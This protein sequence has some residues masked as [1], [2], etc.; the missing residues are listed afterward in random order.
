MRG[1][2]VQVKELKKRY[3]ALKEENPQSGLNGLFEEYAVSVNV[4]ILYVCVCVCV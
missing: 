1:H 4:Q 3:E 2:L